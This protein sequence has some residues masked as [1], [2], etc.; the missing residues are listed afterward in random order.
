MLTFC[1]TEDIIGLAERDTTAASPTVQYRKG[2]FAYWELKQLCV[3]AET[4]K[5]FN[6]DIDIE[7]QFIT[8]AVD[9]ARVKA[10]EDVLSAALVVYPLSALEA[11]RGK[12]NLLRDIEAD[13]ACCYLISNR[14]GSASEGMLNRFF[15][16][17]GV[18]AMTDKIL[19]DMAKGRRK[20]PDLELSRELEK[21]PEVQGKVIKRDAKNDGF[22]EFN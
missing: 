2:K 18:A 21:S 22:Y 14:R 5:Q 9:D 16:E 13:K 11:I 15:G 4:S 17:N 19:S 10:Y 8:Q 3:D 7:L 20:V 6:N 12:S 1:T